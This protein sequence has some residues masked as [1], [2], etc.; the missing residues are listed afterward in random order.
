MKKVLSIDVGSSSGRIMLVSYNNNKISEPLEISRFDNE[1]VFEDGSY[2]WDIPVLMANI[3][4]GI[5]LA[6]TEHKDISSI[7]I[8]GFGVDYIYIDAEGK[9][10]CNPVCYRDERNE[11]AMEQT[12]NVVN[13]VGLYE[14]TGIQKLPYNTIFRLF[15]DFKSKKPLVKGAEKMLM[16]SDYI[17]FVLTGKRRLEIT[18]ASTS[19]LVSLNTK[20]ISGTLLADLGIS[21]KIFANIVNPG[22]IYGYLKEEYSAKKYVKPIPVYA[23]CCHD[24]SS[25]ILGTPID[26]K[27][28][29]IS[30]GTVGV[31]ACE[32]DKFNNSSYAMEYNF[33][34]ELGYK[35]INFLKNTM[36]SYI[37]N[38]LREAWAK[39]GY[40][41]SYE[42]IQRLIEDAPES[43]YY[44]D[45]DFYLFA[46]PCNAKYKIEKYLKLTHQ[47]IPV[48]KGQWLL[49]ILNSM[50]FRY[51]YVIEQ[52]K[53]LT[54]IDFDCIHIVGG[55]SN[56]DYLCQQI[57]NVTNMKVVRGPVE[58]T[59]IGSALVQLIAQNDIKDENEGR[60]IVANSCK[61]ATFHPDGKV[62]HEDNYQ[63]FLNIV[64]L[65]KL[66]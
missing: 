16:I 64:G 21:D 33:S 37:L 17:A 20:K 8:T 4:A 38:E 14:R 62:E 59:S 25:A 3:K 46:N 15:D 36:G 52:I 5:R 58:A 7:G 11:V 30:A 54:H 6:L 24:T 50:S 32:L 27:S 31:I 18:N 28:I 35:K 60:K 48:F 12:L 19:G 49:T 13:F 29:V 45:P 51:R 61:L 56:I 63:K 57:A 9:P 42:T 23:V 10:L 55:A 43:N 39:E 22:E 41:T 1:I 47:S 34:N 26:E 53:L 66:K 2:R 65:T 44:I 40:Q